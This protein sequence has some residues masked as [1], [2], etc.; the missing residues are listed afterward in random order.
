M[1]ASWVVREKAS[2]RVLFETFD[3]RKVDLLNTAK[4]EAVPIE[5][6]LASLNVAPELAAVPDPEYGTRIDADRCTLQFGA[7]G[8]RLDLGKRS[9]EDSPLFG[10]ERQS[11]LFE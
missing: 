2:G 8:R 6:H 9:I 10:G 5:K 3:A 4:Y 7:R 11:G 1:S